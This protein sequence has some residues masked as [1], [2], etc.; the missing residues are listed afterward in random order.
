MSQTPLASSQI[1]HL[2]LA[3]DPDDLWIVSGD[4]KDVHLRL[5]GKNLQ[6]AEVTMSVEQARNLAVLIQEAYPN[7]R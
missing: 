4:G 7:Q 2:A 5:M 6:I 3:L 1:E